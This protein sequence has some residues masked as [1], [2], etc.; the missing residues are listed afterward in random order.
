MNKIYKYI[1]LDNIKNKEK[2]NIIEINEDIDNIGDD[3]VF[4]NISKFKNINI[5][6]LKRNYYISSYDFKNFYC[7]NNSFTNKIALLNKLS[8]IEVDYDYGRCTFS[9]CMKQQTENLV[10]IY[11]NNMLFINLIKPFKITKNITHL[12]ICNL[13]NVNVNL[14]NNLNLELEYLHVSCLY[15][16]DTIYK[17]ENLPITLLK[18]SVTFIEVQQKFDID[19]IKLPFECEIEYEYVNY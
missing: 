15:S 4:E 18:L 12:N 16:I 3:T 7:K 17:L 10:Y 19:K 14:L 1:E 13:N 2:V 6:V 5:L 9:Y 11:N 8:D